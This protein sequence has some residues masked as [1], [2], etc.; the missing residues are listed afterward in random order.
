MGS[1]TCRSS[2]IFEISTQKL[3]SMRF[4]AT[5]VA[6]VASIAAA[7]PSKNPAPEPDALAPR[8][9]S[10][11]S[12]SGLSFNIDGTVKYYAGTNSYWIPFLTNNADVDL[13]MGHLQSAGLK[14]LRVWGFNDITSPTSGVWFQS[15]I[16][17]QPVQ[18][19]TG[20]NGLQRL[21]YV[22]SSA[23]A[24]DIKLI[25]NFVNYWR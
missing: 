11:P 5:A 10:Y 20:V 16:S 12:A 23:E 22:V 25:I 4:L 1:V 21:D 7:L 3:F 15:F 19:N 8:A 18:I 6:I 13:V 2:L 24:H 9:T 14:I 17:D